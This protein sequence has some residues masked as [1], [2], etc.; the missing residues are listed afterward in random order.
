[1][2]SHP[3][4]SEGT[5]KSFSVLIKVLLAYREWKKD[6]IFVSLLCSQLD[7]NEKELVSALSWV[8]ILQ[9]AK[10]CAETTTKD[11]NSTEHGEV[12]I[13][14]TTKSKDERKLFH[15]LVSENFISK[16]VTRWHYK[17]KI[18]ICYIKSAFFKDAIHV[19]LISISLYLG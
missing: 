5:V 18:L 6:L 19:L 10:K 2:L 3:A 7:D 9:L 12:R 14:F 13:D 15:E 1:M 8:R 16:F 4:K 11:G 17:L